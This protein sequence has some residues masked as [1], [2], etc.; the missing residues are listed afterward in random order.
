MRGEERKANKLGESHGKPWALRGELRA[1]RPGAASG[2]D[3]RIPQPGRRK[4]LVGKKTQ[5]HGFWIPSTGRQRKE[6]QESK[7]HLATANECPITRS[8]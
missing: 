8:G 2:T 3:S 4:S 5:H 7:A 1:S 6:A